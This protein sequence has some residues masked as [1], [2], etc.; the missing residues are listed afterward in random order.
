M[1]VIDQTRIL[2]GTARGH[3][4]GVPVAVESRVELSES[5]WEERVWEMA[6]WAR[7]RRESGRMKEAA[8]RQRRR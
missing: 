6:M 8:S 4:A 7:K 1:S 2:A 3:W 5:M